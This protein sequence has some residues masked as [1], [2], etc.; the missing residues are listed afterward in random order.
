MSVD[1]AAEAERLRVDQSWREH[2]ACKGRARV[3][4]PPRDA[5]TA[6]R[7]LGIEQELWRQAKEIC[8]DCPVYGPCRRW[9][10]SLPA[11]ADEIGVCGGL[12]EA[13]RQRERR[14][15]AGLKSAA[16]IK[17]LS[18]AEGPVP[19]GMLRCSRCRGAKPDDEFVL[20]RRNTGRRGRASWCRACEAKWRR[21]RSRGGRGRRA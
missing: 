13:E 12:T 11:K 18:A 8:W 3:M 9:A 10:L 5:V 6:A 16:T 4:D 15:R 17:E 20:D 21:E 14:R 2:A 19:D 1:H 7:E